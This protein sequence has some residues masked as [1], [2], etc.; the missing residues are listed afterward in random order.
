MKITVFGASG[1]IGRRVVDLLTAEGHEVV[2]ASRAT[3]VNVLTAAGVADALRGTQVIVDVLNSP[4]DEDGPA[5]EFFSTATRTLVEAAAAAGVAHYVALS[6]VGV[7][8]LPGSGYMRAKV[9]QETLIEASGLPY[10]IVRATQF[11]EFADGIVATLTEGDIVRVPDA[12][13][14]PIAAAEVAA[15]VARAAV[16]SPAGVVELGGPDKITFAELARVVLA[17]R[18]EQLAVVIDPSATYF[19]AKVD[20]NSLVTGAGAVLGVA[21]FT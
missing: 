6:I 10:T 21:R 20:D 7:T 16:G 8:R 13:I 18:G 12:R 15:H 5:L 9:A 4:S 1:Q 14:Q 11:D 17:R 2:A 3:G 19:G